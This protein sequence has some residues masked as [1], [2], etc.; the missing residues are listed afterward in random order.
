MS[1][2]LEMI[3]ALK[4]QCH[5]VLSASSLMTNALFFEVSQPAVASMLFVSV[6]QTPHG[7]VRHTRFSPLYLIFADRLGVLCV[8]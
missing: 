4:K 5:E 1:L 2:A 7:R 8:S 3:V 6:V